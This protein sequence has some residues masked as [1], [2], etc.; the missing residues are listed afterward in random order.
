MPLLLL[1]ARQTAF[2]RYESDI[3]VV[4]RSIKRNRHTK[5]TRNGQPRRKENGFVV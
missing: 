4:V 2:R 3:D 5:T 1:L